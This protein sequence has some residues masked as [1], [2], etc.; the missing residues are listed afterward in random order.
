MATTKLTTIDDLWHINEPGRFDLIRGELYHMPPAGEE[1]SQIGINLIVPLTLHVRTTQSGRV[2]GPDAGF[3]L[4][5]DPDILLS[6][7]VAFVRTDRLPQ[8]RWTGFLPVPPDLAV[9]I[10][11]PSD[12]PSLVTSKVMQYL[13]AGVRLV[14][15]IEPDERVITAYSPD[16]SPHVYTVS[17]DIDAGEVVPGFRIRV[18]EIFP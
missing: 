16:R 8:G 13:S 12:R 5:R 17:D 10:V 1:H 3:I 6:P 11:S 15:L 14:W 7:D 18:S 9:E 4:A 2:Y